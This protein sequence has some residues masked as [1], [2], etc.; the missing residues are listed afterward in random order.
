MGRAEWRIPLHRVTELRAKD[1]PTGWNWEA[2]IDGNWNAFQ[3][4]SAITHVVPVIGYNY[5][6]VIYEQGSRTTTIEP[7]VALALRLDNFVAGL[8]AAG[9]LPIWSK[10]RIV[11][12][13]RPDG[14]IVCPYK[15]RTVDSVDEFI[16]WC[17]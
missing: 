2:L 12:I 6:A 15:D 14:K 7:L 4:E 13:Q 16:Q 9:V 3:I 5:N 17:Q 8:T 11:G 1:D 10:T